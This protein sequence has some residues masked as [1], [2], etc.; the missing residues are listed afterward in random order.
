MLETRNKPYTTTLG[1][2]RKNV[3]KKANILLQF[4][5]DTIEF[6]FQNSHLYFQNLIQKKSLIDK[7]EPFSEMD[8]VIGSFQY[9]RRSILYELNAM[10]EHWLLIASSPYGEFFDNKNL[11][12]TRTNSIS[13]IEKKYSLELKNMQGYDEVE[14]IKNSVN[15]LKHRGG[16]N[17]TDY[18]LGIP[19]FRSIND[20]IEHIKKL[21]NQST[22]FI[23][24]LINTIINIEHKY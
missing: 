7:N 6:Y 11:K 10:I 14:I 5:I 18:S 22:V 12:R 15:G 8:K 3:H 24:E 19:E 17:F 16:F 4:E 2:I 1:L 23:I 13:I 21:K 9:F 20:D